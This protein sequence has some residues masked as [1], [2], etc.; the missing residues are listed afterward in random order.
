MFKPSVFKVL[1]AFFKFRLVA[2]LIFS[3]LFLQ[4]TKDKDSDVQ[5]NIELTTSTQLII[6]NGTS[7]ANIQLFLEGSIV[8][9]ASDYTIYVDGELVDLHQFNFS[10]DRPAVY[11][12][13]AEYHFY[14]VSTEFSAIVLIQKNLML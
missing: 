14:L 4:C 13:Q 3:L 12:L 5:K 6:A 10:A 7:K 8:Q 9:K 11:R 2:F 1:R